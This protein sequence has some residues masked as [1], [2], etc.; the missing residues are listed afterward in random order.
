MN[1]SGPEI[2]QGESKQAIAH[3]NLAWTKPPPRR[4]PSGV[5]NEVLRASGR[6]DN[7]K[8]S[9]GQG[10]TITSVDVAR[11]CVAF[12]CRFRAILRA[13]RCKLVKI[14][15]RASS[16][17][18]A[19]LNRTNHSHAR[20]AR[21]SRSDPRPRGRRRRVRSAG[22]IHIRGCV[23]AAQFLTAQD[24]AMVRCILANWEPCDRLRSSDSDPIDPRCPTPR[25]S[26]PVP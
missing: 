24:G 22:S 15:R 25:C 9:F 11:I 8:D 16:S 20:R 3:S 23:T 18:N 19:L 1:G 2:G 6:R 4:I 10:E 14:F 12:I 21:S 17:R 26:P 13:S 5:S 7:F